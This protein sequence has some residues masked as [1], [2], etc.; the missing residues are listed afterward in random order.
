MFWRLAIAACFCTVGALA[1]SSHRGIAPAAVT[2]QTVFPEEAP[3]QRVE[4][5]PPER[6]Q[7][8]AERADADYQVRA[9]QEDAN[10]NLWVGSWRGLA[11][12]DPE[13]G[14]VISRVS[15]PNRRIETLAIDKV[16]R[17]WVGTYDGLIRV[18]PRSNEMTAQN[19]LIPSKRVLSLSLD[20][21]G[22]LWAGGDRGLA[23]VSPDRGFTMTTLQ[24]LP[25]IGANAT[26]I[27][28][29]G[30]L[31]VGTLEGLARVDTASALILT[32]VDRLPGVVAQAL[33]ADEQGQPVGRHAQ[34]PAENRRANRECGRSRGGNDQP[35]RALP[36][37]RQVRQPVDRHGKRA[38]SIQSDVQRDRSHRW[39][40]F[41][42]RSL[43]IPLYGQQALD[44]HQRGLGLGEHPNLGSKGS[45]SVRVRSSLK[46]ETALER[47]YGTTAKS[48]HPAV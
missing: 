37:A 12:I 35:Q 15:L 32:E 2:A 19:F 23:L 48:L 31:W 45:P 33:E 4:P 16:G 13:T 29:E 27:D 36:E 5:L 18:D 41:G 6:Q 3:P 9:L 22:Y 42:H 46:I 47:R 20:D 24:S 26:A 40:A 1:K 44:R 28:A 17:I 30:Q 39:A 7:Q 38:V 34:H 21:R 43:A 10:G 14:K 11:L 8:D 25:G